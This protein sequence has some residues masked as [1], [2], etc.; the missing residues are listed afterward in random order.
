MKTKKCDAILKGH[1]IKGLRK[2]ENH[3]T[4]KTEDQI[5]KE[6]VKNNKKLREVAR[7]IKKFKTTDQQYQTLQI[8]PD[9]NKKEEKNTQKIKE[10]WKQKKLK[11]KMRHL[12]E[13]LEHK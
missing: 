7:K 9:H 8:F 11:K 12:K 3:K 13:L 5:E 1:K 10:K 2:L 6:N 4:L